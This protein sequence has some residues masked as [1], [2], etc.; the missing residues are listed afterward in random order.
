[1]HHLV[2][3]LSDDRAAARVLPRKSAARRATVRKLARTNWCSVRVPCVRAAIASPLAR[4][5]ARHSSCK[6]CCPR[7]RSPRGVILEGG[8]HNPF[9]PPFDFLAR[10]FLRVFN[11]F[12]PTV[13]ATL[14]RAGFYPAG[15]GQM[16][17]TISPVDCLRP[18]ELLA[19]G[20]DGGRRVVAHVAGLSPGVAER[21]FVQG[22][23]RLRWCREACEIVEALA[24][25]RARPAKTPQHRRA[26]R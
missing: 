19:R 8:T 2:M 20:A 9:A 4:R 13:D 24:R 18:G 26:S 23:K 1:M 15:G 16:E 25:A 11:R 10:T 14:V 12:G 17:I 22:D 21:A 7:L 3:P 6:R 5:A